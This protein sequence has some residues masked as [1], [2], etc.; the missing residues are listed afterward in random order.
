MSAL[1][2]VTWRD[3]PRLATLETELFAE[4]AWTAETWW[5]ELAGRPRRDYVVLDGDEGIAGYAG[6]DHGGDVAD[7]M[8]VAVVA[9][10]RGQGLGDVLLGELLRR[11]S[12]GGAAS[13]MLEVRADNVPAR[14]LYERHGFE[15][16]SVRPPLLPAA[17]RP[18]RR[19]GGHAPPPEGGVVT[20][21]QPLVLGIETS[22]DE[23]GV[24]IVRGETLLVDAVASSVDEHARFGGVVPEVASRAHLEAM[25]PTIER[26]CRDSGCPARRPRRRRRD[27]RAGPGRGAV[28]RCGRGQ[29]AGR[30]PGQTSLRRQPPRVAR[31]RRRRRARPAP[32]TVSC[33]P[34]QRRALVAVA[35]ARRHRGRSAAG[36]DDRR[37]GGGGVRQGGAGPGAAVPGRPAHRPRGARGQPDRDRL[38][39]GPDRGAATWSGTGSTSRSPG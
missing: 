16:V 31:G 5:A 3:I 4:D 1:R 14:R 19:R 9:G 36:V 20:A 21:D 24:G 30:R 6:L 38:P 11:A 2:E 26:A 18:R 7:V 10:R 12:D 28:G 8:T 32:R 27:R 33:P 34:G 35:R 13:V 37:R 25:V 39:P 29:G 23:T 22:C 15:E 17:G